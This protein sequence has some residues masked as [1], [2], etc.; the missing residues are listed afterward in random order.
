MNDIA[1]ILAAIELLRKRVNKEMPSQHIV[2]L[3]TVADNPG[4]T[5]PELS[6]V[7]DMP[8]GTVSRNVKVLSSYVDHE[9]DSFKQK[10]HNLLRTQ[11][12]NSDVY[13]LAVYLTGRGELLMKELITTLYPD[14]E[15]ESLSDKAYR[16]RFDELASLRLTH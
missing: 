15:E 4:I 3:L 6:R 2:L 9:K 5:M 12:D 10:G 11:P 1:Q 13:C 14:R 7:L 16:K 8:Q